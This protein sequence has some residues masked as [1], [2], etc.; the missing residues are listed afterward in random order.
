MMKTSQL[1]ISQISSLNRPNP[2]PIIKALHPLTLASTVTNRRNPA[3]PKLSP[4]S[5]WSN[6]SFPK[7]HIRT[8][9]SDI[10]LIC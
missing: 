10:E 7:N 5:A 4:I 2:T 1:T 6:L 8:L 9:A 3:N